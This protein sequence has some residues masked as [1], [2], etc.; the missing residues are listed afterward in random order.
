M[1]PVPGLAL[2]L[3]GGATVVLAAAALLAAPATL[4]GCHPVYAGLTGA[5]TLV[6]GL[7]VRQEG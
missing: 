7:A 5:A 2:A 6:G 4:F 3:A 1:K